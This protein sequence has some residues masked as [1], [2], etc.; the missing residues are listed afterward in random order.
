KVARPIIDLQRR[1]D[2]SGIDLSSLE[3]CLPSGEK[4]VAAKQF[5]L[6]PGDRVLVNGP[7]GAGKSTLFRVRGGLWPFGS[8]TGGLPDGARVMILPQ[9]PYLPIGSLAAVISYP[10]DAD[11]FDPDELRETLTAVGLPSFVDRLSEEAHWNR[12]LSLGEQQRLA[13]ARAILQKPDYL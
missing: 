6:A 7:S 2:T 11:Q 12:M 13:L 5:A 10:A 4:L 8:G 9:R 1:K 3:V